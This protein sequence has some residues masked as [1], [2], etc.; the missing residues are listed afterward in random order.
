MPIWGVCRF[1]PGCMERWRCKNSP[2]AALL[3]SS[4]G[5][6]TPRCSTGRDRDPGRK[7]GGAAGGGL[8]RGSRRKRGFGAD[9]KKSDLP[10]L[11]RPQPDHYVKV[12]ALP[13]LGSGKL[14]LRALRKLAEECVA[15]GGGGVRKEIDNSLDWIYSMRARYFVCCLAARGSSAMKHC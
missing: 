11:W 12:A 3:P 7:E 8:Y 14:D 13:L 5:V 10:N 1:Y 15:R 4:R 6:N 2:T 9:R